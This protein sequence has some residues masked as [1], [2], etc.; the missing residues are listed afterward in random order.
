MA[1][2]QI[3]AALDP[4][5]EVALAGFD[6]KYWGIVRLHPGPRGRSRRRFDD[7]EP[8]GSTALHDA[9]DQAAHDLASHGEGRRAVVVIT[10]GVDTASQRPGRGR[11]PALP[12]PR[13]P[14]LRRVGRSPP[15]TTRPPR[16]SRGASGPAAATAGLRAAGALRRGCPAAPP[17][18]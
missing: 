2:I 5:D 1:A 16:S 17:S 18:R 6:N 7:V 3:L 12:R 10:D 11:D 9:L 13:R 15:W 14:H 8:F 4:E